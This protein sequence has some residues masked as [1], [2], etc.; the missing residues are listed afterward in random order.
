[1]SRVQEYIDSVDGEAHQSAV[2]IIGELERALEQPQGE[3]TVWMYR[4]PTGDFY[5]GRTTDL[6][7]VE[8]L[9]DEGYV[10]VRLSAAPQKV[11]AEPPVALLRDAELFLRVGANYV[12]DQHVSD[13]NRA[14]GEWLKTRGLATT[15]LRVADAIKEYL[16][17][18]QESAK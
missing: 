6:E 14:T 2:R 9:K 15:M 1:M 4:S 10:V 11:A 16:A 7:R 3:P 13:Q 5:L 12:P 18:P 17:P 8:Q